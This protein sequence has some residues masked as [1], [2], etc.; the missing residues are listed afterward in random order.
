[1]PRNRSEQAPKAPDGF[2]QWMVDIL[3]VDAAGNLEDGI[4]PDDV[5]SEKK[6]WASDK[7]QLAFDALP[8]ETSDD[9]D[10]HVDYP[11]IRIFVADYMV[12]L[13]AQKSQ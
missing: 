1:M 6:N 3:K 8:N 4:S 10:A 11:K 9:W 12:Y 13:N 7:G 2:P 5:R